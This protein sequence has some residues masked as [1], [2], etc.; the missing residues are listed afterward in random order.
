MPAPAPVAS[1]WMDF[2]RPL[3]DVQ[4]VFF[5][6]DLAVR[7]KIHRGVRLRWLPR[8]PHGERRLRRLMRVLDHMHEEELVVEQA[9]DGAWVQR[10]V[11]GPNA[12]TRFVA[13]FEAVGPQQTRVSM[14][15]YVGPKGFAQG[16]GKLSPLGLEKAMKRALGE[17]RRALE[18]YEPGRA[19]G[20]LLAA[21][22]D[23]AP[24]ARDIRALDDA[25]RRHVVSAILETAWSIA[26]VDEEPDESERDAMRAVVSALWNTTLDAAAE[27][28]MVRAAVDAVAKHGAEARFVALGAKLKAR[29]VAQ[30]GVR[31]AV[32]V[33]EVSHGL[34]PSELD[35]LRAL[36]QAA[37]VSDEDLQKLVR[38]TDELLTG[39]DPISRMSMLV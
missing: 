33:A 36:A 29:G 12:G 3:S 16:L 24:A 1:V 17:Y 11:E 37:G 28:R 23:A 14:E 34:D 7:A 5:D 20:R 30:L 15:A 6:V 9:P 32:L 21:L 25:A 39:D 27:E 13:R 38:R 18:G 4:G 19:R 22:A 26:C 31:L 2:D 10:Y 8:G 35:A